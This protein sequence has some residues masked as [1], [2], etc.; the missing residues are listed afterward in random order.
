MTRQWLFSTA[1]WK[2]VDV[3]HEEIAHETSMSTTPAFRILTQTLLTRK[4]A[5]RWVPHQQ[6]EDQK[7][8]LKDCRRTASL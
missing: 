6:T 8:A 3:K 1:C 5:T 7:A 2:K 4:V